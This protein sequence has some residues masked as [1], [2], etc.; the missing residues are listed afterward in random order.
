MTL[1][2]V[3]GGRA[4]LVHEHNEGARTQPGYFVIGRLIPFENDLWLR[5][6]GTISYP[7]RDANEAGVLAEAL[8][9]TAGALP[10]PIAIEALI[11][12]AVLGGKPPASPKPAS[13]AA[14]AR[15]LLQFMTDALEKLGLREEVSAE[16]M[17]DDMAA[18]LPRPSS[19]IR[20]YRFS[21]DEA[22]AEWMTA[23]TG[24]AERGG[25]G[26]ARSSGGAKGRGAKKGRKKRGGGL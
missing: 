26:S 25:S 19:E 13:S 7:P 1:R 2:S 17:P 23:L 8:G 11:S 24:Q 18:R 10:L 22:L 9:R 6:P 4:H 12:T 5:S 14:E 21:A 15:E 3:R 20:Y 16:E